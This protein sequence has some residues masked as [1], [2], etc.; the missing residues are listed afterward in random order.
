MTHVTRRYRFCASHRLHSAHLSEQQNRACYGKC[1]NPFGHG[2]N[3]VLEV[4][5]RGRV[6]P[7]TGRAADV[8]SL[9]QM[10]RRL[11]LEP[12]DHKDLNADI[13]EFRDL[14]PTT[15]VLALE[16]QRR[17]QEGCDQ[18]FSGAGVRLEKIRIRETPRNIFEVTPER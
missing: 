14:A 7:F 11:V 3:Y 17:L 16:I 1:N 15:E 5:L 12:F 6:D 8:R 2:H 13:P 9:D 4:T 18:E 10:V